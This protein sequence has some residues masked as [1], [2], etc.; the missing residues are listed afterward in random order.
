MSYLRLA[1]YSTIAIVTFM[2][3]L[4]FYVAVCW[5][6]FHWLFKAQES[7]LSM[8]RLFFEMDLPDPGLFFDIL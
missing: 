7:T 4:V 8:T 5:M 6:S 2:M 1:V 3:L